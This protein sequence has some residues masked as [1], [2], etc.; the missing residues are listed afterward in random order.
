MI[1]S[2]YRKPRANEVPTWI[3]ILLFKMNIFAMNIDAQFII[4][5]QKLFTKI[6]FTQIK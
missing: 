5:F 6:K 2:K 4:P 1:L 3:W